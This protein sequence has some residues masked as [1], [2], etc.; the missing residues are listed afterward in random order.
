MLSL[1]TDQ[2]LPECVVTH[3]VVGVGDKVVN[4]VENVFVLVGPVF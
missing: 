1:K 2:I 4:K 3:A